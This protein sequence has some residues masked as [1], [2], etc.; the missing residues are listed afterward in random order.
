MKRTIKRIREK[1]TQFPYQ[2]IT[3]WKQCS[4]AFDFILNELKKITEDIDKGVDSIFYSRILNEAIDLDRYSQ[5]SNQIQK[6]TEKIAAV[7]SLINNFL[8]NETVDIPNNNNREINIEGCVDFIDG[9]TVEV[10]GIVKAY[11]QKKKP[12]MPPITIW[13]DSYFQSI[14]SFNSS[15]NR[16]DTK[17]HTETEKARLS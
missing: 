4:E 3:T 16:W 10:E 1:E 7:T 5:V 13:T 12:T 15:I 14:T 11:N 8:T 17:F 9:Q 6:R 2:S